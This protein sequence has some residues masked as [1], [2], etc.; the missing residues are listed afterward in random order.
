MPE[1]NGRDLAKKLLAAHSPHKI[2]FM[3]G[4]TA[5]IIATRRVDIGVH[6]IQKPSMKVLSAKIRKTD[7]NSGIFRQ[8]NLRSKNTALIA[9]Q[10]IIPFP[11]EKLA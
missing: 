3:S 1:M 8:R 5:D 4:Y 6:F 10:E 7:E 11:H 9:L 2:L